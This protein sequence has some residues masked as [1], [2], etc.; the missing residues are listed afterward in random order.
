MLLQQP[1]PKQLRLQ[2]YKPYVLDPHQHLEQSLTRLLQGDAGDYGKYLEGSGE[3]MGENDPS[4]D[5]AGTVTIA[6]RMS[7]PYKKHEFTLHRRLPHLRN[8][9]WTL[10]HLVLR[11][12][13]QTR[14][15]SA[16]FRK[17][18]PRM[19]SKSL[20]RIFRNSWKTCSINSCGIILHVMSVVEEIAF[21]F[22][23]DR[24]WCA[25]L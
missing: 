19:P 15:L 22:C 8:L 16:M 1:W 24:S 23:G 18:R 9:P 25:V 21:S 3:G 13:M 6:V 5:T 4:A 11:T 12:T 14:T 2:P 10:L 7:I 17:E 20:S